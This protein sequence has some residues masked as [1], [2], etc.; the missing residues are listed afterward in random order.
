MRLVDTH[1]HLQDAAF[2]D[3]LDAVLSRACE[4]G[5]V[6]IIVPGTTLEDSRAA[7]RLAEQYAATPC[8][9]YA[10]VGVHPTNAV[11]FGLDTVRK[12]HDLACHPRVV[13]VGE[14]GLD[15]YWPTVSDR[16]W[17]CADPPQQRE[18]LRLQL[19]LA[20]ELNLPVILH[21]RDAHDDILSAL[22][23]WKATWPD[24]PDGTLHAY[25]AGPERLSEV[26]ELGFH[27]G[28]DG[29]VTYRRATRLHAVASRVAV[30]ALLVETDAP[31]LPPIPYRGRRNEPAY[32]RYTVQ[33]IAEL[34]GTDAEAIAEQT[35]H[36]AH[37]LFGLEDTA[38]QTVDPP[39]V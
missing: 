16:G 33:R 29:P 31:Y 10:A 38:S 17:P 36:N 4:A 26:A 2:A 3:D 13:A 7:V 11:G 30:T 12:L 14:I 32:L 39:M 37:C 9:I 5:V 1:A 15:Y 6:A 20:A 28:M 18:A 19:A 25:A 8:A 35:T 24:A 34:R 27:I 21:D 22:H 23:E